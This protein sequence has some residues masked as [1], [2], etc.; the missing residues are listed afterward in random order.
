MMETLA[1]M[2]L[3]S[4]GF[5]G[6]VKCLSFLGSINTTQNTAFQTISLLAVFQKGYLDTDPSFSFLSVLL[7]SLFKSY[8]ES[9]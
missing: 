5:A 6:E 8:P 2:L 7:A 4:V 1:L 9:N 3:S